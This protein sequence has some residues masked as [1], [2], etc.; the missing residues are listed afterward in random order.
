MDD[1]LF[2]EDLLIARIQQQV[3]ELTVQGIADLADVDQSALSTPSAFVVY[4]GD[5]VPQGAS[6]QGGQKTI[7]T[8]TQNWAVVL[9]VSY[10][11]SAGDG[12]GARRLAGPYLGQLLATLT[13]WKPAQDV[14]PL[15]RA[16]QQAPTD[17]IDG[18]FYYPLVFQAN[19][20]YPRSK[21]WQP[22]N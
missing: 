19:F 21:P 4:L 22:K 8:V 3:P 11:D 2:L 7:Q 12:Y 9:C 5:W 17:Y 1:Y 15:V 6:H 14:A 13:G 10:G 18:Y 16:A 20:V